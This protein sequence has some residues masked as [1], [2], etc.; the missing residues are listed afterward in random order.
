MPD[1]T[2]APKTPAEPAASRAPAAPAAAPVAAPAASPAPADP[3]ATATEPAAAPAEPPAAPPG[4]PEKYEFKTPDG[5]GFNDQVLAK[6]GDTARSLNLPQDA[7]QKIL[8]EVAPAIRESNLKALTDFYADIG[9]LPDT[10]QAT[11]EA[12]KEL[13][14][15][16][17]AENLAVAKKALDL[18]GPGLVNVLAK[19]GLGNHPEVVRWAFKIGKSLS[20]EKIVSGGSGS[21]SAGADAAS[22]LYGSK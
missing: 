10:W 15:P 8:D 11:V 16:R 13:G 5:Q 21:G 22:K 18:G 20:E 2:T 6:F 19:T 14:G 7:A 4:A 9:G 12:D 1:P 3:A 17:L